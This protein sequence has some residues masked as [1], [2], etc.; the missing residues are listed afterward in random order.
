VTWVQSRIDVL[1]GDRTGAIERL[2]VLL[3]HPGQQSRTWLTID[4]TMEPLRGDPRFQS[5]LQTASP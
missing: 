4:R 3:G 1:A 5:L 2:G